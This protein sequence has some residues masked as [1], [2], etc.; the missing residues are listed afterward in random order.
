M[1]TGTLLAQTLLAYREKAKAVLAW[2]GDVDTPYRKARIVARVLVSKRLKERRRWCDLA[3][4]LVE[5]PSVE[6]RLIGQ[7]VR[8]FELRQRENS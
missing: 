4:Q 3:K 8:W 1:K 6:N 7:A 5:D 2:P